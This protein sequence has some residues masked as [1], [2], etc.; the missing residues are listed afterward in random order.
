MNSN[1]RNFIKKSSSLAALSAIGI[2]TSGLAGLSSCKESNTAEKT[3]SDESRKNV[4]WPVKESQ[5][6]PKLCTGISRDA[7]RDEIRKIKQIGIDYVLTGGGGYAGLTYNVAY[8][9]AMMQAALSLQ[10]T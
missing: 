3:P 9:R 10:E 2:S 5:D 6:T 4:Q 1:R 8:A 7:D